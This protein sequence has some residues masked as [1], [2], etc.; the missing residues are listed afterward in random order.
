MV[1]LHLFP[2]D[3]YLDKPDGITIVFEG[4]TR[5]FT[6]FNSMPFDVDSN[7][8]YTMVELGGFGKSRKHGWFVLKFDGNECVYKEIYDSLHEANT[9]VSDDSGK[10]VRF[11]TQV[12][13]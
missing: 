3:E 8:S 1:Q 5:E 9:Y 6:E 4:K 7:I 12:G 2:M 10:R 11:R 13:T